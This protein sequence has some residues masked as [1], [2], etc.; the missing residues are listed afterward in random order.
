MWKKKTA[1]ALF[2][3]GIVCEWL[4]SF[5]GYSFGYYKEPL[6]IVVGMVSFSIAILLTMN[7]KKDW[8]VFLLFGI[9]GLLCYYYQGAA[10]ILRIA[11]MLLAGRGQDCKKVMAFFFWGT[12]GAMTYTAVLAALGLHNSMALTQVFRNEVETRYCYGFFH[13]NG[14]AFF[15]FRCLAMGIYVYGERLQWWDYIWIALCGIPPMLLSASKMGLVA[16]CTVLLLGVFLSLQ[17]NSKR[18]AK[19]LYIAG[20]GI[21]AAEQVI[22]AASMYGVKLMDRIMLG[23]C[24]LWY[25]L[26]LLTSGRVQAIQQTAMEYT[27]GFFGKKQFA[28]ATEVGYFNALYNQGILFL[29]LYLIAAVLLYRQLYKKGQ[30]Y[31]MLLF[32]GFTIYGF[33]E[34]F[35]AYGNKN[36]IWLLWIGNLIFAGKGKTE[37]QLST[38]KEHVLESN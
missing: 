5:S 19:L 3:L 24:S 26:A 10:L 9:Y 7:L 37:K 38:G 17:K 8:P 29:L 6:F 31:G 36:A 2:W 21:L 4:V 14:F 33:A 35:L 28:Y 1:N 20:I 23:D 18:T 13:P 22:I 32:L 11:L 34:A 16:F 27:P 15:W 30:L 12:L 25:R